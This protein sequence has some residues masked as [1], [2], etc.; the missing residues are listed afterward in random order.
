[1]SAQAHETAGRI[2]MEVDAPAEGRRHLEIARAL[3]PGRAGVI[4]GELG[5]LD[6]LEGRWDAAMARCRH[7]LADPDAAVALLGAVLEARLAGWRGDR[8]ASAAA[9]A[10]FAPRIGQAGEL[11]AFFHQASIAGAIDPAQWTA[12]EDRF[13]RSARPRRMQILGL[14][15]MAELS[16]LLDHHDLALR[17]LGKATDAGLIDITWL[18]GCPLFPRIAG[19]LR[20]H[21]IRDA[22]A[23]RAAGVLATLHAAAS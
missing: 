1:M 19:D 8:D 5:R 13:T 15:L 17:A 11:L 7:L 12:L 16:I 21:A 2:L 23:A 4:D 3:D 22:V 6:A 20:Y 9:A 10:R 14:Q 18:G